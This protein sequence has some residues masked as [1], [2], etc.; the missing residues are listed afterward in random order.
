MNATGGEATCCGVWGGRG[1][2]FPPC[3]HQHRPIKQIPRYVYCEHP[4][5][6]GSR[7]ELCVSAE[8]G[9]SFA[10]LRAFRHV[11]ICSLMKVLLHRHLV[12]LVQQDST[13]L[14]SLPARDVGLEW[15]MIVL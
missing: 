7:F 6:I 2:A 9:E 5:L 10:I 1:G 3:H 13:G 8:M 11:R 14:V 12:T 4:L 15:E